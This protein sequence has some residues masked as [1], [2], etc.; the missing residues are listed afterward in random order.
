RFRCSPS[1]ET[2]T[3]ATPASTPRSKEDDHAIDLGRDPP[4]SDRD[5]HL[6][7]GGRGDDAARGPPGRGAEAPARALSSLLEALALWQGTQ[8]RAA[9][10]VGAGEGPTSDTTLFHESFTDFG[11]TSL[12]SVE[13]VS[14]YRRRRHRDGLDGLGDFRDLRQLLLFEVAK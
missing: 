8:V 14:D 3:D 7:D 9:L 5:A 2:R 1:T 12:Y 10:A 6:G 13:Y 4:A 11:R